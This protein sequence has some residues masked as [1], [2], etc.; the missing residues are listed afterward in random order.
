[1]MAGEEKRGATVGEERYFPLE[2]KCSRFLWK[3]HYNPACG[4]EKRQHRES[5]AHYARHALDMQC[6]SRRAFEKLD[7]KRWEIEQERDD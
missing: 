6:F 5:H 3:I 1:M 4:H 2:R 7:R